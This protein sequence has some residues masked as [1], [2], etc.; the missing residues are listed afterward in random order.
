V[1]IHANTNYYEMVRLF[2]KRDRANYPALLWYLKYLYLAYRQPDDQP[3][4]IP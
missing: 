3:M 4:P 1:P 2:A